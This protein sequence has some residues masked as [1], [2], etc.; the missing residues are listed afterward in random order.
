MATRRKASGTSRS[1]VSAK[2]SAAAKK[3]WRTRR[4]NEAAGMDGLGAR[5]KKRKKA[6]TK[7]QCSTAGRRLKK[8][9]SSAAGRRL[10]RK[11]RNGGCKP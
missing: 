9:A 7:T 4:R 6:S 10:G 8:Y 1:R 3:A 5:V 11:R 2:R